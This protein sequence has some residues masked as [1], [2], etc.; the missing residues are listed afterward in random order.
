MRGQRVHAD[1]QV[2][3][4]NRVGI[5]VQRQSLRRHVDY[6]L[7]RRRQRSAWRAM[8]QDVSNRVQ[9][10]VDR[11]ETLEAVIASQPAA[12]YRLQG[13]ADRFVAA[14]YDSLVEAKNGP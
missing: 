14:I 5:G 1:Q 9:S 3:R 13:D 7:H 11:G 10:A 6:P 2:R 4:S 8:L 12:A